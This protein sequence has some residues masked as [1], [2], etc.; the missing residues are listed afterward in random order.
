MNVK[1]STGNYEIID[2]GTI[3]ANSGESIVFEVSSLTFIFEFRSDPNKPKSN[4][5]KEVDGDKSLK[6]ILTNF[7]NSLGTRNTDPLSIGTVNNRQL[8][9]NFNVYFNSESV[10]PTFHYSFLYL[11]EA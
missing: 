7:N 6:I 10:G 11:K 1:I 3:V 2:S 5:S 9:I 8:F 4:I